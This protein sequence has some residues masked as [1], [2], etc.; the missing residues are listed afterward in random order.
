MCCPSQAEVR[1]KPRPSPREALKLPFGLRTAMLFIVGSDR[2][3]L[4][5]ASLDLRAGLNRGSNLRTSAT[6]LR[7]MGEHAGGNLSQSAGKHSNRASPGISSMTHWYQLQG[8]QGPS[9]SFVLVHTRP[10]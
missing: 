4:R 9:K 6:E 5:A 7:T 10:E 1:V 8:P 2:P 3:G